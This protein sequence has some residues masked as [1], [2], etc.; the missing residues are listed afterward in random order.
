MIRMTTL[1]MRKNKALIFILIV[2]VSIASAQKVK[3][4]NVFT[5]GETPFSSNMSS[6]LDVN[7]YIDSTKIS[8]ATYDRLKKI[9]VLV[10]KES[11]QQIFDE[12][13][14]VPKKEMDEN[15]MIYALKAL[16]AM[17]V[18]NYP[19]ATTALEQAI[20][21]V[22]DD[23]L[24]SGLYNMLGYVDMQGDYRISAVQNFKFSHKLDP[25][26]VAPIVML[27]A[28]S[29]EN[30]NTDDAISYYEK[31]VKL[32]PPSNSVWNNLGFLYQGKGRHTEAIAIF[33]KTI[34]AIPDKAAFSFNNRA[35]SKL[36]IGQ[37]KE[38]LADVE[39]SIEIYPENPYAFR[40]RA[41]IYI[42]MSKT[43]LACADLKKAQALGF[44]QK[45]G[46]E[47]KELI[48]KYCLKNTK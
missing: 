36:Q 45:F 40:N 12:L 31:A 19:A 23:A 26:N 2:M 21:N 34:I 44:E 28:V 11:F 1:L 39:R 7:E 6:E 13:E 5:E 42:A 32:V 47:V 48:S 10:E 27:G 43:D 37:A 38:A 17:N 24:N 33:D 46:T 20:A 25:G 16:A 29:M 9:K 15:P 30:G 35:Y 4:T 3:K 41:L 18:K 8:P 22:K 14:A